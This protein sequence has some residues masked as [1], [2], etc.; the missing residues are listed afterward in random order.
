VA[1]DFLVSSIQEM[2]ALQVKLLV[3]AAMG[4]QLLAFEGFHEEPRRVKLNEA[5][6]WG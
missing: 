5:S 4:K 3:P 2:K 6:L 1:A